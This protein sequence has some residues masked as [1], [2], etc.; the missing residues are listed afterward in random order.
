MHKYILFKIIT[1][2]TEISHRTTN[3]VGKRKHILVNLRKLPRKYFI[4]FNNNVFLLMWPVMGKYQLHGH[5]SL[6]LDEVT[7][8]HLCMSWNDYKRGGTLTMSK[9]LSML[10]SQNK[11]GLRWIMDIQW[12][13]GSGLSTTLGYM[14]TFQ[15]WSRFATLS[16]VIS[17]SSFEQGGKLH[18]S[19]QQ[20]WPK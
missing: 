16:A 5:T 8:M 12:K 3:M 7:Y 2:E 15:V 14:H 20:F 19:Y 9:G 10:V 18:Q 4:I 11:F 6:D 1:W 17:K 13:Q